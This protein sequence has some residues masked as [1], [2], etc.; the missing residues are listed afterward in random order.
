M[1]SDTV[2]FT[3]VA[4]NPNDTDDD[5]IDNRYQI[6]GYVDTDNNG[7]DDNLEGVRALYDTETGSPVG[8]ETGSGT[9]ADLTS[10]PQSDI[11]AGLLPADTLPYGLFNFRVEGLPVDAANPATANLT[12]YFPAVLPP[13]ARWYKYDRAGNAMIDITAD[14]LFNGNQAM[15]TLADGGSGD[16]DGVINGVIVDPGGPVLPAAT[17]NSAAGSA[18]SSGA[19]GGGGGGGCSISRQGTLIDPMRPLLMIWSLIYLMR[20]RCGKQQ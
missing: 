2:G 18:N 20:R 11:P 4:A 6:A 10:T 1:W 14:V 8:I 9:L 3:T 7:V 5:G 19:S 15:L 13:D 17:A 16:A 12:F